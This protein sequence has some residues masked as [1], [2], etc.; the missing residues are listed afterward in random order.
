LRESGRATGSIT[1]RR[2]QGFLVSSQICLATILLLGAG[3]LLSSFAEL[4]HVNPGF[5]PHP[6]LTLKSSLAGPSF[7]SPTRLDAVVQRSVQHLQTL[8]G[9]QAVAVATMLPTG[10]S[11]QLPFELPSLP[12]AERPALDAEVQWR[13]ISPAY[14]TVMSVPVLQGRSFSESDSPGSSPVVIVNQAFF[15]EYFPHL[16]GMGQ[17]VLIGRREGPQFADRSR[18]IVG[19]V[20]DSHELGLSE[21]VAPAVFIPFAQVPDGLL[22]FMNRIMPM[23]WL[24]RVSGAP[25]AYAPA[26]HREL[27]AV[28]PDLV[29]SNPTPLDQLLSDSLAQQRMETAL[30][31]FFSTAALLLGAIGLYGVL[32][33]SVAERRREIA[34]RIAVGADRAQILRLVVVHGLK[35]TLIGILVGV[36]GGLAL[37]RFMSSLLFGVGAND[38]LTF[39]SVT[40][41]LMLVALAAC[42]LPAR[43]AIRVDPMIALR[44]E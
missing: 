9:I 2:V 34:I 19:V 3:L 5:D 20:A 23:N 1:T 11:V 22:V 4:L 28:D 27:L 36:A 44:Y 16:D 10:P 25:L 21:P 41:L 33:Y 38:P 42:Y 43:R 18:Q 15:R 13:A 6:V 12:A 24:F 14:F 7:V 30:V 29:A 40:A 37:T 8:P 39:A 35:L 17:S 31:G 26:I 32:S